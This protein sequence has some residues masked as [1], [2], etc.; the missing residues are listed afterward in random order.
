M[1]MS[2]AGS[3]VDGNRAAGGC[4]PPRQSGVAHLGHGPNSKVGGKPLANDFA[5]FFRRDGL[6]AR[7]GADY[8]FGFSNRNGIPAPSPRLR[9][10][11]YL[12][13]TSQHP[14]QPQRGCGPDRSSPGYGMATTALRLK[15]RSRADPRL[16]E[17][18]IP[19]GIAEAAEV[20]RIPKLASPKF[21]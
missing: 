21:R 10:T 9:A 7:L 19:L 11:S 6:T 8:H 14:S 17:G 2:G 18:H 20:N 4:F 1:I 13:S 16:A 5:G 15:Q 12:G 3:W